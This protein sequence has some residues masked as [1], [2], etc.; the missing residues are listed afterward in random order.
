LGVLKCVKI[1]EFYEFFKI[2]KM[3]FLELCTSYCAYHLITV[4]TFGL[5]TSTFHSRLTV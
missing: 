4:T 1:R 3:R 5:I 2:R